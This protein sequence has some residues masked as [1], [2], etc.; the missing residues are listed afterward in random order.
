[1]AMVKKRERAML[2]FIR[3]FGRISRM[4]LVKRM[5]LVSEAN[6]VYD[7]VPYKFGPFSFDLYNDLAHLERAGFVELSDE[8][9][10]LAGEIYPEPDTAIRRTLNYHISTFGE[11]SASDIMEYVYERYPEYTI[12][13]QIEKKM[14]YVCDERGATTIGY[15]GRNI[16]QFLSVLLKNKINTLIDVRKNA[17]SMKYGFSKGQ[18]SR[19]LPE[20]RISYLHIPSLGIEGGRRKDLDKNGFKKLF[21]EYAEDLPS[22]KRELDMISRLASEGKVALMCFEKESGDCHRE[23]IANFLRNDGTEVVDL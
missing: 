7:F 3:H 8:T 18:L 13:S 20:L 2:Y 9:V 16:D 23:V 15:E 19:Y 11:M 12:F 17:F 5:F 1:M 6:R 14:D 21:D 22:K 10:S 4:E